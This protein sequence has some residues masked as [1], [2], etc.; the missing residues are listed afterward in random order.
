MQN[1][2]LISKN[3]SGILCG[4]V[5]VMFFTLITFQM[6]SF[7]NQEILEAKIE[8]EHTMLLTWIDVLDT[9]D[10]SQYVYA[11]NMMKNG[12]D[13]LTALCDAVNF[14]NKDINRKCALAKDVIDSERQIDINQHRRNAEQFQMNKHEEIMIQHYKRYPEDFKSHENACIEHSNMIESLY[15]AV[16][17]ISAIEMCDIINPIEE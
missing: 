9:V 1:E 12:V 10:S 5:F 2:N 4:F 7:K 16:P 8:S 3:I 11:Y 17:S 15:E 13:N 6:N 14:D